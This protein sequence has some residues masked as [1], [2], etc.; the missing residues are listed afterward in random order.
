MRWACLLLPH[1]ALD[2]VLRRLPDP[3]VAL[4]LVTGPT[5]RRILHAV[6]PAARRLGLRRG[7]LLSAAQVLTREFRIQDHDPE[8]EAQARRLLATWAYGYSSQVSTDMAH[9]L[10]LEIGAS[11]ALFGDWPAIEQRLRSELVEL[12]FRHRLVAAPNPFAARA[13][14]NVHDGVEIEEGHLERA[15]GQIP[16]ERSGLPSEVV[17][18]LARSG[19]RKLQTVF[20]LPRD[21]MA[22]RFPPGVLQHLDA[23]RGW[24]VPPLNW[25][26]PPD[27][28]EARIEFEQEVESS[29]AL[30]FPLRRL[31][32]DLSA[33][34]FSRDGGVQQF[35]LLFEHEQR[36]DSTLAVG[37]LTP[38]REASVLFELAR[39]RLDH[40]RLPAATRGL[41]LVAEKLPPFVPGARDLFDLRPQQAIP[42]EQLRERL[43]AR[44]GDEAVHGLAIQQDHRPERASSTGPHQPMPDQAPPRPTWLL[45]RPIPLRGHDLQ[46]VAGPERIESGWWDCGDIRRDYYVVETREGQRAWAYT[47]TGQEGSFLLH[48]WF[49]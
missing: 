9:A 31:T 46:I 5:Q 14:V 30:L 22:R 41:R 7:M 49:A 21:S 19:L 36:P 27:R 8:D 45:P 13:L 1:L 32:Q 43:R 2:A 40:L 47:S 10:V 28:F 23:M 34:L 15:L 20:A 48:G 25:F 44:L 33:F 35:V 11:R 42:W 39:S 26:Q 3:D 12:G 16:I 24:H 6:S 17:I 18:S 4:A 37:L 29:Q 38:E